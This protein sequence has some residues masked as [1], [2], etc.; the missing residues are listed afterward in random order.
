[1]KPLLFWRLD[2]QTEKLAM[3]SLRQNIVTPSPKT[4]LLAMQ[5]T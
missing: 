4:M 2:D 5:P 3:V 1:M